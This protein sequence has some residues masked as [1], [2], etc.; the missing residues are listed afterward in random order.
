MA[1]RD[2][3]VNDHRAVV[4]GIEDWTILSGQESAAEEEEDD[5]VDVK[6]EIV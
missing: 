6:I 3:G 2:D 1:L 5:G 4:K